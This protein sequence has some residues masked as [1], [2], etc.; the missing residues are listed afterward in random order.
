MAVPFIVSSL[1]IALS[2]LIAE[3]S[4]IAINKVVADKPLY[5]VL[6]LEFVATAEL[7]A[8]CFELVIGNNHSTPFN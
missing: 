7:C 4:R 6:C 1:Y 8:V 5:R 2:I 3:L